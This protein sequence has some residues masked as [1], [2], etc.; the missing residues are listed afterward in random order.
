MRRQSGTLLSTL[1]CLTLSL[2]APARAADKTGLPDKRPD[3]PDPAATFFG[4]DKHHVVHLRLTEHAWQL[5]QPTRRP[6]AMPVVAADIPDP[7]TQPA[8]KPPATSPATGSEFAVGDA[9]SDAPKREPVEGDKLPPNNFGS[10][11]V[12]VKAA[13]ECD[14]RTLADV[15]VRFKGNSSYDN[16]NR[17]LRRPLKLDFDRFVPKQKFHGM[18]AVNLANNAFDHSQLRESLSYECYRRAGV[19]APRTALATVY[20]TVPGRYDRTY[21][22]VYTFIEE[23]DEKPFLTRH[24][25]DAGGVLLKPEGIRGLPYMGETW[26]PYAA[27]Y[28]AK[29]D[30]ADPAVT[31][32]FIDLVK[33]VNYADDE[34]FRAKIGDHLAVDNLL[35]YL[36]VSMLI[37]NLDS[38]LVTNHNY[39]LYVSPRDNRV[40][41]MPWDMNL[42]FGGYGT[43]GP[44]DD[45]VNLSVDHPWAGQIKLFDRV[46]AIEENRQAYRDHVRRF[47]D[48]FFN[49]KRMHASIDT[50]RTALLQADKEALAANMPAVFDEPP[51]SVS[52][53]GRTRYTLKEFAARRATSVARQLET[54]TKTE[55]ALE[56]R[57]NPPN[58]MFGWAIN[59]SPEFGLLPHIARSLRLAADADGDFRLTGREAR[60]ALAG[61]YYRIADEDAPD[62]LTATQLKAGLIP[63]MRTFSSN[64][65]R[66]FL[67]FG[68]GGGAETGAAW[69]NVVFAD[70]DTDADGKVTLAELT[71]CADRLFCLADYD[72]DGRASERELIEG[73]DQMATPR[74]GVRGR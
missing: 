59:A 27:Q 50:M 52:G 73:L 53:F 58:Q 37:A 9:K 33:L 72:Q 22:G 14:G 71:A 13:F 10:E 74:G 7:A 25:G 26:P 69:A 29:T 32:R 12:Y 36:A 60:D 62:A 11:F 1:L 6:R 48:D 20:L 21:V 23:M 66:G 34:T 2:A 15:A 40:H 38:A 46:L 17:T 68:G 63:V 28:R 64:R 16:F 61:L 67:G 42:S 45:Q 8:R 39:Y 4:P 49:E 19:P 56:P 57:P 44:R 35:R 24:F 41:L 54:D 65:S 5:M 3:K 43:A 47:H 18:R 31:K 70:A 51:G 55:S 30:T